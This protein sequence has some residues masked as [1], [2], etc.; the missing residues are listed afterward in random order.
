LSIIAAGAAFLLL[1]TISD[2][3]GLF[4]LR[5]EIKILLIVAVALA[6]RSEDREALHS[7][8]FHSEDAAMTRKRVAKAAQKAGTRPT[9]ARCHGGEAGHGM[10]LT[11]DELTPKRQHVTLDL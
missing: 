9:R 10:G 6:G 8:P 4:D 1:Q 3:L 2:I 11:E 5:L 7:V